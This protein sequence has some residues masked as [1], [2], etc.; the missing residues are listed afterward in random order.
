MQILY[1]NL[2]VDGE[3]LLKFAWYFIALAVMNK[4]N[5]E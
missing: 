3:I 2:S 1:Q 5:Y 4:I